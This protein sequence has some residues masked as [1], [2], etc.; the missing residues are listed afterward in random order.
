[1]AVKVNRDFVRVK[2][3]VGD[4]DAILIFK[5]PSSESLSKLFKGR[6]KQGRRG[7]VDDRSFEARTN[8]AKENLHDVENVVCEDE[9]GK[10]K[11]LNRNVEGWFDKLDP[12]W[13]ISAV[14]TFEEKDAEPDLGNE[15]KTSSTETA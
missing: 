8:F 11:P 1:M 13:L 15:R 10:D 4:E 3:P 12:T 9:K 5:Q 2:V 7:K 6:F 14:M